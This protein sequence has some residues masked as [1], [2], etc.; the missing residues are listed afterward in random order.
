M[1]QPRRSGSLEEAYQ[2]IAQ[3]AGLERLEVISISP[4]ESKKFS[5]PSPE[6]RQR[7]IRLANEWAQAWEDIN[8]L[9]AGD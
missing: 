7:L 9:P 1:C 4:E 6:L 3:M 2:D 5:Q 8:G